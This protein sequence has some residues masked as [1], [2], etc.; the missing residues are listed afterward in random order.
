MNEGKSLSQQVSWF[1]NALI[2]SLVALALGGSVMG[3]LLHEE[4]V[5]VAELQTELQIV[6]DELTEVR[7]D[8]YDL[9]QLAGN[10]E[11]LESENA[12]LESQV[13]ALQATVDEQ[14]AEIASLEAALANYSSGSSGSSGSSNSSGSSSGTTSSTGDTQ[15]V[16]V[17]VTRTGSKYH[18]A[19]CQ[20]LRESQIAISL[21]QAK[22]QGYTACS[23][24]Y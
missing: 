22:S 5:E 6:E 12:T 16:T 9:E 11:E 13:A 21:S 20:Y 14:A 1:R 23:R 17:Y 3:Y 4:G 15:S 2:G 8:Y 24:C 18:K 19:G 7:A 10:A